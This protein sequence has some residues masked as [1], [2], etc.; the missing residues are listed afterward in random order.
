MLRVRGDPEPARPSRRGPPVQGET[1]SPIG[2]KRSPGRARGRRPGASTKGSRIFSRPKRPHGTKRP[3]GAQPARTGPLT[4]GWRVSS[5]ATHCSVDGRL[6]PVD[7]PALRPDDRGFAYG[8]GAF[9]TLRAVDGRPIGLGRHLARLGTTLDALRIPRPPIDLPEELRRVLLANGL[10]RG[11]ACARIRVSRGPGWGAR[12]PP[13]PRPTVIVDASP[14]PPTLDARRAE[15]M[16]VVTLQTP[17]RAL[18]T[19]KTLAWLPSVVAL[20]D[21]PCDAE[22]IF[23]DDDEVLE[24]AT[25]NIFALRPGLIWTPPDDGRLLAGVARAVVLTWAAA[26]GLAVREAPLSRAALAAGPALLTNALLRAAPVRAVDAVP[27]PAPDI[28]LLERLHVAY[29]ALADAT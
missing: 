24:G 4:G 3:E 2:P 14:C 11:E 8:D 25:T 10:T 29:D 6:V 23:C 27:L 19:L 20:L 21:V 15:G 5:G 12:P 28:E 22:A 18:P 17:R 26:S 7:Q 1:G 9:E 13:D 16:A